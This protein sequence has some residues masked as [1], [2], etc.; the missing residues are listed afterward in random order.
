M[1]KT[2]EFKAPSKRSLDY[3]TD[4]VRDRDVAPGKTATQ[5]LAQLTHW[6]AEKPRSQSEVSAMIDRNKAKAYRVALSPTPVA[7]KTVWAPFPP[8]PENVPS[9][10]FAVLTELLTELPDSWRKQEYLFFEVK[11]H[12]GKRQ[13]RRLLGAP[14]SFSR[15]MLPAATASELFG[16]L[17]SDAFSY[18]AALTFGEIY[19]CCGRCAA[20][21]TDD[22]SRERKFGP[23][24]W[25]LM[26]A[27]R[28]AAGL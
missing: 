14:G 2:A 3:L 28:A 7:G 15:T 17:S 24:C 9:S 11:E 4:L 16:H 25:D 10:K 18:Q 21:L 23:I 20:E 5:C 8:V 13:V 12:K 6:L 26:G 1:T 22:Q 19:Q 27:Y